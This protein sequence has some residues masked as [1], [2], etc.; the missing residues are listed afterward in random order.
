MAPTVDLKL[1]TV[2]TPAEYADRV[3]QSLL[4][5][6][7]SGYT[8]S[9]VSGLGQ[10]QPRWHGWLSTGNVRIETLVTADTA[11]RILDRMAEHA[12]LRIL[13]F[14]HDVQAVPAQRFT[15]GYARP[16]RGRNP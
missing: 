8:L 11:A 7:A 1:V 9:E 12:D 16:Q 6:G 3:E 4:K 13:A 10:R 5:L 2:I 15:E 14:A